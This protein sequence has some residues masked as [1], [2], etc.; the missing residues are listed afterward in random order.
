MLFFGIELSYKEDV[1]IR[2]VSLSSGG[3]GLR[4]VKRQSLFGWVGM[5]NT[6]AS[7]Y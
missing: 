2:L 1:G 3:R 7:A 6:L 4:D 5:G